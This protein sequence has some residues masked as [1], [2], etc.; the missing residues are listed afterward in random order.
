MRIANVVMSSIF[1]TLRETAQ[2]HWDKT[3]IIYRDVQVSYGALFSGAD[4]VAAQFRDGNTS[5]RRKVGIV[6]SRDADF[7]L[8]LLALMQAGAIAVPLSA[9]LREGELAQ[10]V[11][12]L[13]LD[14]VVFSDRFKALFPAGPA[15]QAIDFP[16]VAGR[17][18]VWIRHPLR[19]DV[20]DSRRDELAKRGVAT[21]RWSSGT[22]GRAKGIMLSDEAVWARIKA[23]HE[24]H[25]VRQTDCI[26]FIVS[27]DAAL[28]AMLAY[29]SVGASVVLEEAQNIEWITAIGG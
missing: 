3:C 8:A 15:D 6:S 23:H 20:E 19:R 10:L 7:M 26:L 14:E 18:S 12:E 4:A 24:M 16:T 1:F 28:P 2:K 25:D 9:A 22:T 29:L 11:D 17:S 13:A 21:I 27:F 5:A